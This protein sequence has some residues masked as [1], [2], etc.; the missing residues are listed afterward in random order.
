M[1]RRF[2]AVRLVSGANFYID[3]SPFDYLDIYLFSKN[4]YL[5][6]FIDWPYASTIIYIFSRIVAEIIQKSS[7]KENLSISN[8]FGYLRSVS[9]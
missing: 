3:L 6:Q 2:W 7:M 9:T 5:R 1:S 8:L 4:I